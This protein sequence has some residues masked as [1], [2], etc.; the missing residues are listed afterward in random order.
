MS[1]Q[2]TPAL[3]GREET[4]TMAE[5]SKGKAL[6]TGASSGIG[7]VYADRL[8]GR[9]YDLIL[10]ARDV[11]RMEALAGRL[12]ADTGRTVEVIEADL[13]SSADLAT[14]ARRL[15]TDDAIT[16]LVNNA[17]MNLTGGLLDN[18]AAHL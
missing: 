2:P 13:T 11:A 7:A 18:D 14:V 6:V 5:H 9:G 17:G 8:A 4:S 16:L 12:R 15:D 10:A 3:S 1:L